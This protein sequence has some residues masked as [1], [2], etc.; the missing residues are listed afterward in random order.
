MR[1]L[2]LF[3]ALSLLFA[4]ADA[5]PLNRATYSTMIKTAEEK[6]AEGDYY[7]ALE[8]YEKAYEE[9]QDKDVAVKIANMYLNLRDYRKAERS[10]LRVLRR[11]RKE[12][13][14]EERFAFAQCLK[15][16]E[17]YDEAIEEFEKYIASATDPVK[18]ELAQVELEGCKFAKIAPDARNMT[19][20]N[21]GQNVNSAYS[22]YSAVLAPD[23]Q[24][25]YY[26]SFN[27][28]EVIVI[29]KNATDYFA[30]IYAADRTEDGWSAGV[31]LDEKI[32]RPEYHNSNVTLSPDGRR[33]YFTRQ[34]LSANL[35]TESKIYMSERSGSAWGPANEVE[36]VNGDYLATH[37]AVGELYGN[38]VLFFTSDME[39]GYGGNDIYYSTFKNGVYGPPVNLGPKINTVGDEATP[40]Y[41]D[42]ILY[43]SSTGHPGLGG[44]D[45]F[46]SEWNG[47]VWSEPV[48]MGKGYNSSVDDL[49]F[50]LDAEGYSGFLLSNRPGTR[51]VKSKGKTC[52]DDIYNVSLKLILADLEATVFDLETEEE[53]TGA[54]VQLIDMTDD[55]ETGKVIDSQTNASGN[56]FAY[57]LELDR[58]YRVI[59]T[60]KDYFP[61]TLEFNTMG[62]L[63]NKTF[64]LPIQLKPQPIYITISR[65]EPIELEYIYYDFD[66]D[67][68]LPDAEPDLNFV[69]ELMS[70]YPDMVIELSSHTDNRGN[71]SYNRDLSQRRAES[72]RR[73]LI[74][75]G[76]DRRRIQAVGYGETVPKTISEKL[77]AE[78]AFL[79]VGDVLTEPFIDQLATEE[80][81]EEAHQIN[82]RTEFKI[83]A[84]PT[85]ISIEETR[86]VRKGA[87]EVAPEEGKVEEEEKKN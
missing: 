51:W 72:A 30:K 50:M 39:G 10:F 8:W 59:A 5:Q 79:K 32:N 35:L 44:F 23:G 70:E 58:F 71:D 55:E 42:G 33:M 29:D 36:G 27:A 3:I 14:T 56:S 63:D 13:Y 16:N 41:R 11:D 45:I 22:E 77:A 25:M 4:R 69:L 24:K 6:L 60:R 74:E 21:A 53:L 34:I 7:N 54:T 17:K 65:E 38:E 73:W 76:V 49:Y 20:S 83:V 57:P 48:N 62:L 61:D 84:G 9:S 18:K 37:P 46:S 31:A 26:A 66:D 47:S 15:M 28:E 2:I 86:L 12:Q 87:R 68:I 78:H 1:R 81:K 80:E 40:Y 85:S 19:I 52:C 64:E 75:R 82:R 43:F 67:K